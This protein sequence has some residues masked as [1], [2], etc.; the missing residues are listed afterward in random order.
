MDDGTINRL[1]DISYQYCQWRDKQ[2]K[3]KSEKPIGKNIANIEKQ[4]IVEIKKVLSP[5]LSEEQRSEI[6]KTVFSNI[7]IFS[8]SFAVNKE[9]PIPY[10]GRAAATI[11]MIKLI[12]NER[13]RLTQLKKIQLHESE[14]QISR[15]ARL[16]PTIRIL[17]SVIKT[18][19]Y[20]FRILLWTK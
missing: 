1:F 13:P 10:Q 20:Y 3:K 15:R 19:K 9:S 17:S 12:E 4:I 11:R 16:K 2:S 18:Q 14:Q 7:L 5:A 6:A 8:D